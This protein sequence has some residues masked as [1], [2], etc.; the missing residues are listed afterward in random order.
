[1]LCRSVQEARPRAST[2]GGQSSGRAA[3]IFVVLLL[4]AGELE[5]S[6]A[7]IADQAANDVHE[8]QLESVSY[9]H[10]R[11]ITTPVDSTRVLKGTYGFPSFPNTTPL[12]YF[13]GT[14]PGV[15]G[16]VTGASFVGALTLCADA[17]IL[18]SIVHKTKSETK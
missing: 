9:L 10:A 5:V 17:D 7:A 8:R 1:M 3:G 4:V 16:G 13:F 18:P 6:E 15:G 14:A 12:G 2:L 11:P